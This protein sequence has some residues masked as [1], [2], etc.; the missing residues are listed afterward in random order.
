MRMHWVS[1]YLVNTISVGWRLP[2]QP[3]DPGA[4]TAADGEH[5]PPESVVE[6]LKLLKRLGYPESQESYKSNSLLSKINT[7]L[8]K[9]VH[10]LEL[11][12]QQLLQPATKDSKLTEKKLV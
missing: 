1:C 2:S 9:R 12:K 3:G 4:S 8:T 7:A 6:T 10:L 11:T 5:P